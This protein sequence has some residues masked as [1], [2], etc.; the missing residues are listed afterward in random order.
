MIGR[1]A[2]LE[3]RLFARYLDPDD[4]T[5]AEV[6]VRRYLPMARWVAARFRAT[7]EPYDDIYQ[8]AVIGLLKA[9][10]RFDPDRGIRFSSFAR[11]TIQ[12]ELRRHLRD[13]TW[14]VHVPRDLQERA[15]RVERR[16]HELTVKLGHPPTVDD[17]AHTLECSHGEIVEARMA[18]AARRPSSLEAPCSGDDEPVALGDKL[19]ADEA[20]FVHVDERG[21]VERMLRHLTRRDREVVRLRYDEDLTQRE[22]GQ[23]LGLSQMHVSRILSNAL[24]ELRGDGAPQTTALAATRG[25]ASRERTQRPGAMRGARGCAARA[26]PMAADG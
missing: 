23:R 2:L 16:D 3:R 10:H 26:Q 20:G 19:G 11:P 21:V 9:I 17:L 13:S 8:V 5:D 25:S 12:G 4:P 14:V 22:I 18:I 24:A 15:V 6:L 7:G 1:D